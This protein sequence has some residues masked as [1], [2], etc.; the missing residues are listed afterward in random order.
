[1]RTGG[2]NPGAVPAARGV[3][4]ALAPGLNLLIYAVWLSALSSFWTEGSVR[5]ASAR[6]AL[7]LSSCIAGALYLLAVRSSL[8]RGA[9]MV[10][11]W[12]L[13]AALLARAVVALAPPLLETDFQRYLWD[14]ALVGHGLNPYRHAPTDV[15]QGQ[16]PGEEA[17]LLRS[18]A[19][20][21]GEHLSR[22]N[23]PYLTTIYPP[24][25]QVFFAAAWLVDPF[26]VAGLRLVFLAFDA[27][28]VLLLARWLRALALPSEWLLWYVANPL[29]LREAHSALHMD[30]LLLPF[31]VGA[32]LM[33]A[34]R[35]GFLASVLV[36][37]A[38]AVKVWPLLLLPLQGHALGASS[39]RRALR[40]AALLMLGSALWIPVL[41]GPADRTNGF[42]AYGESWQNNDGFF[43]L[44]IRAS[45][46]ALGLLELPAWHS[47]AVMRALAFALVAL[48]VLRQR[49]TRRRERDCDPR[50][51][52]LVVGALFLLSPTQ[53]PWYWLW[54]LPL[55]TVTP[56]PPLLLYTALLP[57]YYLQEEWSGVLWIE[58][59]PVWAWLL[60]RWRRAPLEGRP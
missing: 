37:L 48:V 13:V 33:A 57:L 28:T 35:R 3:L 42:L 26:G 20:D 11:R 30:V 51:E 4:I 43:R 16:V 53:F 24:L 58:H 31:L 54:C 46:L 32:G 7:G 56:C 27:L 50:A 2:R 15:A 1:M 19:A 36:V 14:G 34:R 41:D 44:G 38:S 55:L 29:L 25:A 21:S 59:L 39:V 22:I 60:W 52:L 12:T 8:R 45:E 6:V 23:H 18:I 40:C 17:A 49:R 5:T 47:H 9:S 10:L